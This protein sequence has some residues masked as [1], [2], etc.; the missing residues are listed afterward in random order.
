MR[1]FAIS[2][3]MA[4]LRSQSMT[5]NRVRLYNHA[6]KQTDSLAVAFPKDRNGIGK[7]VAAER[8]AVTGEPDLATP[9]A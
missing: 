7:I 3:V 9:H 4:C 2:S 1:E 6:Q 5:M 8:K